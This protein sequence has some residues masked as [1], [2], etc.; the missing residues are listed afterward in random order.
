[1]ASTLLAKCPSKYEAQN[2]KGDSYKKPAGQGGPPA[3][4]G[5]VPTPR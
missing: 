2:R 3:S 5:P 4:P 1:M